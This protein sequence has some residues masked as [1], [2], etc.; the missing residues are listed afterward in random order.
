MTRPSPERLF[1]EAAALAFHFHWP[2]DT[3]LDL[4]HRDRR[5]FLAHAEHLTAQHGAAP[6]AGAVTVPDAPVEPP[7]PEPAI[8]LDAI[9]DPDV[10]RLFATYYGG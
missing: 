3:L 8:D 10:R 4:E 5:A 2:L 1:R 9:K 7:A 6:A